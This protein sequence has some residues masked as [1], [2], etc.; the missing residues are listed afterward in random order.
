MK[1]YNKFVIAPDR[2]F[3]FSW[4]FLGHL[5]T[6]YLMIVGRWDLLLIS[7]MINYFI[8]QVGISMTYH[9]A[10]SHRAITLPK[11]LERVGTIIGGFA[12]QGSAI[13]WSELHRAHHRLDG[14]DRDPHSPKFYGCF[15]VTM[16]QWAFT[17]HYTRPCKDISDSWQLTFHRFY[18]L[19]YGTIMVT[20]LFFLNFEWALALFWSPVGMCAIFSGVVNT[21]LS[22]W[23]KDIPKNDMR[24]Q[25]FSLGEA[26]HKNH[27]DLPKNYRFGKYDL[28]GYLI[29]KFIVKPEHGT[30]TY[31]K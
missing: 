25:I 13:T 9:R 14:T 30:E 6:V 15:Y 22:S 2:I 16:C 5:S 24:V 8:G 7:L 21:W 28:T 1:Q 20:S 26:Y 3:G 4:I 31:I 27:H 17:S 23:S 19:I 10:L 18:Y 11:W 29:E 12:M